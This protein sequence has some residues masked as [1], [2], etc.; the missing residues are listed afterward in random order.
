MDGLTH[1]KQ[2]LN[3]LCI[4][5][6]HNRQCPENVIDLAFQKVSS[7]TQEEALVNSNM[8]NKQKNIIPFVVQYNTR[9]DDKQTLE[10]V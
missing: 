4:V 9:V 2:L 5:Y 10:F 3:L 1:T 6:F 7:L 8:G